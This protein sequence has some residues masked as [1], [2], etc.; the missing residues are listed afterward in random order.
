S[1]RI[2]VRQWRAGSE[3]LG[4]GY[5]IVNREPISNLLA[6]AVDDRQSAL[7][8][9]QIASSALALTLATI[10]A[11]YWRTGAAMITIW[12][13]SETFAHGFIVPPIALWL[14]W[15]ARAKLVRV[16]PQPSWWVLAL[17]P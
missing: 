10:L 15:R 3:L 7:R 16:A 4:R 17:L 11:C 13:R 6:F 9:W 14:V 1:M 12:A 2:S 5:S 8:S